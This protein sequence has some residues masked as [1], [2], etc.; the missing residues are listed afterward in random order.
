MAI[1]SNAP[2]V[3]GYV[4]GLAERV[5]N[6]QPA[7][8]RTRRLLAEQ[9]Q[10]VWSTEGR[11]IDESWPAAA[12]PER[13][14]DSRLLVATGALRAAM[15]DPMAGV[16]EG[17]TLSLGTD[18]PYARFHQYGTHRMPARVFAGLS[19]EVQR[20]FQEELARG[21]MEGA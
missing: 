6:P 16:V 9:E 8:E 5:G 21:L 14:V 1:Q 13:K 18:L 15:S 19:P 3:A 10:Q 20:T 17:N 7:L 12:D 2:E 11:T 4:K